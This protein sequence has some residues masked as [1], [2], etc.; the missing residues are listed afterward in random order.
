MYCI[1]QRRND[2]KF[3]PFTLKDIESI[4]SYTKG[5]LMSMLMEY[6]GIVNYYIY[7]DKN[8]ETIQGILFAYFL[9]NS[10]I[11]YN[12]SFF[13][14]LT[15]FDNNVLKY[16]YMF[17]FDKENIIK[18][19]FKYSSFLYEFNLIKRILKQQN[20]TLVDDNKE[21]LFFY[22]KDC[23]DFRNRLNCYLPL[24]ND[25]CCDDFSISK[26]I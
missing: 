16:G 24:Y 6:N 13:I 12:K 7:S 17:S 14:K 8:L 4:T 22:L 15:H 21:I 20:N 1:K 18:N 25:S 9:Q 11:N 26:V 3:V 2:D 23:I 19:N 5:Q 10:F